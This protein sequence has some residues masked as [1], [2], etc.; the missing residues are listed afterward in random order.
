[1][2]WT[3]DECYPP[4]ELQLLFLTLRDAE[5]WFEV[6]YSPVTAA[7]YAKTRIT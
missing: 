2:R 6:W 7:A 3:E 1:M 5:P 4:A